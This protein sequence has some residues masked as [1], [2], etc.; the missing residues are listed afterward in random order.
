VVCCP[1]GLVTV[2]HDIVRCTAQG[3]GSSPN[4]LVDLRLVDRLDGRVPRDFPSHAAVAAAHDQHLLCCV[5]HHLLKGPE[6]WRWVA[7]QAAA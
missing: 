4:S 5:L 1:G 2:S 6:Q 3:V 7:G